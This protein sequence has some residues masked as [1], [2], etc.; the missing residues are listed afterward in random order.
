M[1]YQKKFTPMEVIYI[2][3]ALLVGIVFLLSMIGDDI[4]ITS[5]VPANAIV[6]ADANN[7]IYY[8]PPYIDNNRYPSTLDITVLKAETVSAGQALNQTPDRVCV[9]QG[10]FQEQDTLNHTILWK[11]GWAAP[12][13][14]RWNPDGSWNW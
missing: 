13:P 6:Y 9:E 4:K 11:L 12:K 3:V 1:S 7:K 10:Y 8:A 14:S 5:Q 2:I